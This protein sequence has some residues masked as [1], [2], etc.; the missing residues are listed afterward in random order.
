MATTKATVDPIF[1]ELRRLSPKVTGGLLRM[2]EATYVDGAL[3]AWS[4]P[5]LGR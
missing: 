5:R 4:A 2:R 1:H 3:S